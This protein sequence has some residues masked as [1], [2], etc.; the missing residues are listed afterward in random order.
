[1]KNAPEAIEKRFLDCRWIATFQYFSIPASPLFKC[2]LRGSPFNAFLWKTKA[3]TL[4]RSVDSAAQPF[5]LS[6]EAVHDFSDLLKS[7][8]RPER[9]L[10]GWKTE[11]G[12]QQSPLSSFRKNQ[13]A[14]LL[15]SVS[16]TGKKT[17]R[18][19]SMLSGD[20]R[21]KEGVC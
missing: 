2:H 17:N 14:C 16:A 20:G 10:K 11:R 8:R 9:K 13:A 6:F 12:F 3:G 15:G 4:N 21:R 7:T 1:M 18:P 19:S 5:A